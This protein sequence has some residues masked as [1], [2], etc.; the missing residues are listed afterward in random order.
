MQTINVLSIAI[1]TVFGMKIKAK[2]IKTT[3]ARL[4][5]YTFLSICS[6]AF[7]IS[8]FFIVFRMPFL[9]FANL[10][11]ILRGEQDK[12]FRMV[13]DVDVTKFENKGKAYERQ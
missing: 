4:V 8:S 11:Y 3:I 9:Y 6:N 1:F 12:V 5:K 13:N 10:C 2:T 7:L